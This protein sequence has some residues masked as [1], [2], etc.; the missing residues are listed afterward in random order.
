MDLLSDIS[1]DEY[2]ELET[3]VFESI[4]ETISEN[5][6]KYSNPNFYGKL[7]DTIFEIFF[8]EWMAYEMVTEDDA[9]EIYD[10]ID[11]MTEDFFDIF[12]DEYPKLSY[13]CTTN[14]I[15]PL[16]S[17]YILNYTEQIEKIRN[18]YQPKQRTPEWYEYRHNL[19]T[20]SSAHKILGSTAQINSFIY[21]KCKPFALHPMNYF[22]KN[23]R[24]WGNIYEPLSIKIYEDRFH[25]KVEDFGCIQHPTH[26]FLG[27]SPDGIN[28][29]SNS[30]RFGRMIEVKN[31]YNRDITGI[32]KEDYWVQMQVQMETCDLNECDFIE[33][34]FKEYSNESEF[35]ED[36]TREHKG[37]I[38][39]FINKTNHSGEQIKPIYEYIPLDVPLDKDTVDMWINDNR[40]LYRETHTLYSTDYWYLD[41]FSCILVKR[42][43]NWFNSALPKI[44]ETWKIIEVE[45]VVG[46]EHRAAKKRTPKIMDLL[47]P[48]IYSEKID[49]DEK[50]H[51]IH[52]LSVNSGSNVC[53]IKL[54]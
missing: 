26:S 14:T 23:A 11:S 33:T 27:A 24:Q 6:L 31:I 3:T 9:D 10:M 48:N 20:A 5:I 15:S 21:E 8:E 49:N 36:N 41:E 30:D 42:N 38:L 19:I 7:V 46:Y 44:E 51:V 17:D 22:T 1:F 29:D 4:E 50:T 45:R 12:E 39:C 37:I 32:P 25:T 54:E 35:Y 2:V 40:T 52:N 13:I 16:S 28:I 53:L 43:R 34:R 47:I 18:Y